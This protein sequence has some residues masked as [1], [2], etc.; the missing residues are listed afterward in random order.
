M[1]IIGLTLQLRRR[2]L[3]GKISSN[4]LLSK[5]AINK[6]LYIAP[7][8]NGFAAS[9]NRFWEED[10]AVTRAAVHLI[11][12]AVSYEVT[13]TSNLSLI[14]CV[15]TSATIWELSH[16]LVTQPLSELWQRVHI[17]FGCIFFFFERALD[18]IL[19]DCFGISWQSKST[20]SILGR[21]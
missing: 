4:H 12:G 3:Y 21:L 13:K 17:L 15:R 2:P 14:T 20:K 16:R 10:Y 11:G 5:S 9:T 6:K 18:K 8:K 1:N 7:E 19:F